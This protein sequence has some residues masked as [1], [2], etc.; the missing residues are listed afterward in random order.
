M[1]QI[2]TGKKDVNEGNPS[3]KFPFFTCSK[4]THYSDSFSFDTEAIL[5]AGNGAVGETKYY[6]GK[7]EAYQRTYVLDGFTAFPPYLYLFLKF[8]LVSELSKRVTGSTMPYIRKGDLENI[9]IPVPSPSEQRKIAEV[10][11]LL[12]RAIEQQERLLV[13]T[14]Q[15]KK[16]L[17]RQLLTQGLRDEP[18]EQTELGRLPQSWDVVE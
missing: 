8:T 11:G 6:R 12:Q 3:G 16:A 1:C 2:R 10:L 13:L 18:Q 15:L 7:F 4:E 14:A 17:L 5:V 9:Q